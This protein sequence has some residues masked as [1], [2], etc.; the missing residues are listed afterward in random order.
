ML[1]LPTQRS[2]LIWISQKKRYLNDKIPQQDNHNQFSS[3]V[4]GI[5]TSEN[6]LAN[7]ILRTGNTVTDRIFAQQA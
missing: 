3:S 7:L 4:Q 2:D 6:Y 1:F 5:L